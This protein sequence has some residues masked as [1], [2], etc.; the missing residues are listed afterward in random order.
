M[1]IAGRLYQALQEQEDCDVRLCV[2]DGDEVKCHSLVLK[3][4]SQYFQSRFSSDWRSSD[5]VQTVQCDFEKVIVQGTVE[6]MYGKDVDLTM[7]NV[8]SYLCISDFYEINSLQLTCIKYLQQ[9]VTYRNVFR[10]LKLSNVY[11]LSP[12]RE[13]CL[14]LID[15]DFHNAVES[16]DDFFGLPQDLVV[17]IIRRLSLSVNEEFLCESLIQWKEQQTVESH[18]GTDLW[19]TVS[20]HILFNCVSLDF[21]ILHCFRMIINGDF[22]DF[23]LLY[24]T[25]LDKKP[26]SACK[27]RRPELL[28]DVLFERFTEMSDEP[29]WVSDPIEGDR[30]EITSDDDVMLKGISVYGKIDVSYFFDITIYTCNSSQN[31]P[32]QQM[33]GRIDFH[34]NKPETILLKTPTC[35][36]KDQSIGVILHMTGGATY[37]GRN[38]VDCVTSLING[39]LIKLHIRSS[40]VGASNTQTGQI[41][42]FLFASI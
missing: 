6:F 23:C 21:Y 41:Y 31:I 25:S 2:G 17:M 40:K 35:L 33:K 16:N 42:G 5:S 7:E 3:L 39:K 38:G 14:M 22:A 37:Y 20:P 11:T 12:L 10:I 30:I 24:L 13:Q 34:E 29:T 9:N 18:D 15:K 36:H 28:S 4:C 1:D 32:I 26:T 19:S 27:R 8:E